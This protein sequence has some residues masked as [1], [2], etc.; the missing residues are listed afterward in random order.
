MLNY[1]TTAMA[2]LSFYMRLDIFVCS[3]SLKYFSGNPLNCD[4]ETLWLRN[5][6]SDEHSAVQD[7]PICYFPQQLSGNPLKKLRTSRFTC[8]ARS[9]ELIHDA[10]KGIPVKT[11]VQK[12]LA[13]GLNSGMF[14]SP[15]TFR[16]TLQL[17]FAVSKTP[18]LP[19]RINKIY[20]LFSKC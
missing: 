18:C 12:P 7:E 20:Y 9:T 5:W 1:L 19:I 3:Y 14:S 11:P 13:V 6:V 4:C 15:K 2:V 10:C 17:Y 16:K 8:G